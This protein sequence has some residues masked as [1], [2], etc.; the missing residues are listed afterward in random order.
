MQSFKPAG[1]YEPEGSGTG[2]GQELKIKL[3]EGGSCLAITQSSVEFVLDSSADLTVCS[4]TCLLFCK[5]ISTVKVV[6][7]SHRG[8]HRLA[9]IK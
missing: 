2:S 7:F 8:L 4:W 3:A 1:L 5:Y 6:S 9:L